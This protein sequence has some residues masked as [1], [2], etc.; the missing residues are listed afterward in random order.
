MILLCQP[1]QSNILRIIF[2]Y[3]MMNLFH[4]IWHRLWLLLFFFFHHALQHHAKCCQQF[5]GIQTLQIIIHRLHG[6]FHEAHKLRP[7]FS[8][9]RKQDIIHPSHQ[10]LHFQISP[11]IFYT[12]TQS[13][14]IKDQLLC[15]GNLPFLKAA[16]QLFLHPGMTTPGNRLLT[17]LN[18]L[19]TELD[20]VYSLKWTLYQC[21]DQFPVDFSNILP[22]IWFFFFLLPVQYHGYW[23]V[24]FYRESLFYT[25]CK[26]SHFGLA[27]AANHYKLTHFLRIVKYLY[28]FFFYA[29][30][31]Q[32]LLD[33]PGCLQNIMI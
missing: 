29:F 21:G 13:H 19:M 23:S 6:F 24:L 32:F 30:L 26:F 4:Q 15:H 31:Q 25:L 3:I 18:R 14:G 22:Q 17:V 2:L 12:M 10:L 5:A 11:P 8:N 1:G 28:C 7:F 16:Q 20:I 33:I 9:V 27:A